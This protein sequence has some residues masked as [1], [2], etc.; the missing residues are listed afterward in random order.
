MSSSVETGR[1]LAI[2][3]PSGAGK[4]TLMNMLRLKQG[5]GIANGSI[6]LNGVPFTGALYEEHAA[7]V[8]QTA[9]VWPMLTVREQ[10]AYTFELVRPSLN[11]NERKAA[12]DEM[13]DSLGLMKVQHV[14]AGGGLSGGEL[15]RL[16]LAAG[17]A[18]RPSL[19]F[20]DE[21]T[22]GLDSAAAAGVMDVVSQLAKMANT[23]VICV[24]HQPSEAIY[25]KFDKVLLLSCGRT[26][27]NGPASGIPMHFKSIGKPFPDG[28][29]VSEAALS[30]T[31]R[32]FAADPT[33][34]DKVLD[35][36]ATKETLPAL[37]SAKMIAEPPRMANAMEQLSTLTMRGVVNFNRDPINWLGR[38]GIHIVMQLLLGAFVPGSEWNQAQIQIRNGG[39]IVMLMIVS[40][41]PAINISFY[42]SEMSLLAKEVREGKVNPFVY[43]LVSTGVQLPAI[44]IT[45]VISSKSLLSAR[46]TPSLHLRLEHRARVA[47]GYFAVRAILE[48]SHE[49]CVFRMTRNMSTISH[50]ALL[51]HLLRWQWESSS[52]SREAHG[53]RLVIVSA[54]WSLLSTYTSPWPRRSRPLGW[55]LG[56]SCT[57]SS[58]T[59]ATPS[60]ASSRRYRRRSIPSSSSVPSRRPDRW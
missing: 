36:W 47:S 32:D 13:L 37:V 29:S 20:L 49:R 35:A 11:A 28:M 58:S 42:A 56:C 4:T 55:H 8:E 48:V 7:A 54:S 31:N 15:R 24:I 21:P 2:I 1:M 5:Q 10:L 50:H 6:T 27:Y 40:M 57:C 3:G 22:T 30:I 16:S 14:K 23:A 53:R 26:A 44:C 33:A 17:L 39:I 34:V 59:R 19:L 60:T 12:I 18:K 51:E 52:G 45:S 38:I 43:V 25:S 41:L 9:S 46:R